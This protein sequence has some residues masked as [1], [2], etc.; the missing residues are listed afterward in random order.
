MVPQCKDWLKVFCGHPDDIYAF[1]RLKTWPLNEFMKILNMI[2][3]PSDYVKLFR[4]QFNAF[5]CH[6][7]FVSCSLSLQHYDYM[8]F[9]FF[10][11]SSGS[12]LLSILLATQF[13]QLWSKRSQKFWRF[14]LFEPKAYDAKLLILSVWLKSVDVS[15]FLLR[16]LD[17]TSWP[18]SINV[19]T[20]IFSCFE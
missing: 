13:I 16:K 14:S 15:T 11:F 1:L 4:S 9:C 10:M 19:R 2:R 20:R 5:D 12:C 6:P 3:F 8:I 7:F 18:L 17:K